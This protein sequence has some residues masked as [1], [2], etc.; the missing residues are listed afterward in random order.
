MEWGTEYYSIC[1][2]LSTLYSYTFSREKSERCKYVMID[3]WR[4][5]SQKLYYT[6]LYN[7]LYFRRNSRGS[8][9]LVVKEG[10][11]GLEPLVKTQF[12][13]TEKTRTMY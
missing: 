10:G 4:N 1:N 13:T 12:S 8:E 3:V 5:C 6:N 9:R 7:C 2:D 11:N